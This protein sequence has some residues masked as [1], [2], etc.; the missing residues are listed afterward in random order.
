MFKKIFAAIIVFGIIGV[1][2][3]YTL[4][5]DQVQFESVCDKDNKRYTKYCENVGKF[6][7][8]QKSVLEINEKNYGP[9]IGVA[10]R[11]KG[12]II[13]SRIHKKKRVSEKNAYYYIIGNPK[14]P[15]TQFLRVVDETSPREDGYKLEIPR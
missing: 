12:S 13:S 9:I 14:D 7:W 1:V 4:N 6:A 8:N 5:M 2:T 10:W 11:K 3:Y 15:E